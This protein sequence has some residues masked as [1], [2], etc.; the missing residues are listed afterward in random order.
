MEGQEGLRAM[1]KVACQLVES[2]TES[3]SG[4]GGR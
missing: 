3:D 4:C 2:R 1:R